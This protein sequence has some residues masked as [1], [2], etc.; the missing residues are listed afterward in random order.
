MNMDLIEALK[1]RLCMKYNW[2]TTLALSCL[3]SIFPLVR[4]ADPV[5]FVENNIVENLQLI[6]LLIAFFVTLSA[7][8]EKKFFIFCSM[9]VIFFI[10]RE[11]NMGR[12][13]FCAKYLT[14]NDVCRWKSFQYGY[15]M[16]LFRLFFAAYMVF[17]MFKYK[18]YRPIKAY[19]LKAPIFVW[20]IGILIVSVIGATVSEFRCV[21][22]EIMEEMF[23]I[24]MYIALT[25]CLWLYGHLKDFTV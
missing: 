5:W 9:I 15:V 20:D 4:Y 7:K 21:D 12:Q 14:E 2:V 3:I 13:Y 19:V 16:E 24:V 23:E 18:V 25:K 22:N 1:Q 11:T 17:Y 10:M 6:I 8:N